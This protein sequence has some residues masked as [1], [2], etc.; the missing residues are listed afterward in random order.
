M[1]G[2]IAW[3]DIDGAREFLNGAAGVSEFERSFSEFVM[4]LGKARVD[5]QRIGILDG[6]FAV[7]AFVKIAVATLQEF[8]LADV[9]IARAPGKQRGDEEPDKKQA[10]DYR[11]A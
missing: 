11:A 4:S 2:V 10:T 3:I 5:L 6:R 1:G 8:L 9:G 7:F